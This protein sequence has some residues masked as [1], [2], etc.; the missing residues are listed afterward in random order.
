MAT[1]SLIQST[2]AAPTT[3][4]M[5]DSERLDEVVDGQI[6]EKPPASAISVRLAGVLLIWVGSF[7]LREKLGRA[8]N[9]A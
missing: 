7:L 3:S 8:S 4:A 1:A 9:S 6:L 2:I 5:L